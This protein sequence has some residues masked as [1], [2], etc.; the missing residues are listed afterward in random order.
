VR[1]VTYNIHAGVDGYGRANDVVD[2]AVALRADL[3]FAQEVWRGDVEDQYRELA[4]RL[5][6][7]GEFVSLGVGDRVTKE[8]GG[9]GW[10][11][12]LALLR[13]EEGLYF[14]ERRELT[15]HQRAT[16]PRARGRENGEWGMCLLTNREVVDLHVEHLPQLRRDKVR[17]AL[18]VARL[19]DGDQEFLAVGLHGAHLTHGSLLQYRHAARRL[20][21]IAG[22]TPMIV[23]GDFNCWRPLLRTVLP[24]YRSGVVARTWPAWRAHSQIDHLLVRGPWELAGAH[25]VTGPSDHRALVVEATLR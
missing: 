7:A 1:V 20:D 13:G 21:E 2:S 6:L 23:G 24:G 25:A 4:D 16:R 10:Q 9:R 8:S 12:P 18:L 17:R 22:S 3:L 5:G 14:D 15:A 19:R 11:A